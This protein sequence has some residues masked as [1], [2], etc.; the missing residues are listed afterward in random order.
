MHF[1]MNTSK[2]SVYPTHTTELHGKQQNVEVIEKQTFNF[3]IKYNHNFKP[4]IIIRSRR[5]QLIYWCF[6]ICLFDLSLYEAL[7]IGHLCFAVG[8]WESKC[9]AILHLSTSLSQMWQLSLVQG[10]SLC[11]ADRCLLRLCLCTNSFFAHI[12]H[13]CCLS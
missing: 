12:V 11:L 6:F 9:L 8:S 4:S 13:L 3:S 2:K 1:P 5:R 7:H 10:P